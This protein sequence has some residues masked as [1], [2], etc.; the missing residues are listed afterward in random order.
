[1]AQQILT[2]IFGFVTGCSLGVGGALAFIGFRALKRYDDLQKKLDNIKVE[3][4]P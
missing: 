3:V 1:M 4:I 2:W